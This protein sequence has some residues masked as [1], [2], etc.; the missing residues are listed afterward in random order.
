[1]PSFASLLPRSARSRAFATLAVAGVG[2]VP[3]LASG[4]ASPRARV[5]AESTETGAS[6]RVEVDAV[7]A[8]VALGLG[9][10]IEPDELSTHAPLVRRWLA[11]GLRVDDEAG[12]CRARP[13]APVLRGEDIDAVVSLDVDYL[14]PESSGAV[15]L[16]DDGFADEGPT[17]ETFVSVRQG[18]RVSAHVLRRDASSVS[19]G[20]P[21]RAS[22]TAATFVGEGARHL[23]AG[24][25]HLLFLISLIL[26]AGLLVEREGLRRALVDVARVVTAFTLGHS[27]SLGAAALGLVVLPERAVELAIAGSIVL[28]AM[29]NVVRPKA[30]ANSW[31][32]GAFGLLHG[33]GFSSVLMELGLPPTHRVLALL[34]FNVGIELAQLAFVAIVLM[35]LSVAARSAAYQRFVLQGA[36]LAIAACG[37]LWVIERSLG[38]FVS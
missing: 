9:T 7:D 6:V 19:L 18:D 21:P 30:A 13:Q 5:H 15:V 10:S 14:C 24:Y 34:S 35:P 2:L 33:F 32:A 22:E 37:G 17:H 16:H 4:H 1:M 27:L 31:L 28:V 26:G 8:A 23:V 3:A 11:Q 25:D 12:P 20:R 36:S 29:S 38:L